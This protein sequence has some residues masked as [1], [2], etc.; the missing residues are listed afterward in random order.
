MNDYDV[1][2]V[3]A[4]CAGAALATM[5]A[6]AGARTL[7]LDAVSL[8]SD[9][10][11]S[12]H[13][14]HPP[15]MD[16]LD[17]LGVGAAVRACTPPSR[18]MRMQVE[19]NDVFVDSAEGRTAYC[20]RRLVLD[21]LLLEA[22]V[23]AGAELRDRHRVIELIEE[24]G[25]VVG[26]VADSPQGRQRLRAELVVGAD[27]R[28]S[29]VA[30]LSGVESYLEFSMPRGGY[31]FYQRMPSIWRQDPDYRDWDVFLG[32]QGQDLRYV[33]QCD[34][35]LLILVAT[36]SSEQARAWG[37]DYR[38]RAFEHLRQCEVTR[39]LVEAGSPEGKGV[40][41]LRYDCFFR[42]PVGPGFALVGDAGTTK[43]FVTGHGITEALLGARQLCEAIL[44]GREAAYQRFWRR[45]DAETMPLYFNA[46]WLGGLQFNSPF[47]R[48][49]FAQLARE[50]Q[51]AR[52]IAE[53]NDRS[54]SA[55]DAFPPS[56]VNRAIARGL[57]SGRLSVLPSALGVSRRLRTEQARHQEAQALLAA[58]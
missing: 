14:I 55:F 36:T 32:W 48:A 1:I 43:D 54:I 45:R 39:P 13:L 40:G 10:P 4:R 7:L 30:R 57:L 25:R 16:V 27:G 34:G 15:G 41:V 31:F 26:V 8:P 24:Q 53:V 46:K 20:T 6:R 37:S 51:F 2:I 9:M 21:R 33:F 19:G 38:E 3:G 5:L 44:D 22:A 56:L 28:H 50:P 42:R 58:L 18:R 29:T 12:T 23:A 47:T 17:E 35:D 11:M 49:L 52:R